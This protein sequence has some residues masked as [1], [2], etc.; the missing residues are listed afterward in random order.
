MAQE[1]RFLQAMSAAQGVSWEGEQ[2]LI[3]LA[4]SAEPL[5]FVPVKP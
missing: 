5:R 3:Q 4:D 1:D 2:L